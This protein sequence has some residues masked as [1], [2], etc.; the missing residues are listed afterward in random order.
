M[1]LGIDPSSYFEEMEAGAKYFYDGK[2]VEPLKLF[3]E[4]GVKLARA[5][6]WNDPYNEKGEPYLGGTTDLKNFIK[7]AK[8]LQSKGYDILVDFHYSDFWA[9]P[10][11]QLAP[12][13]WKDMTFEEVEKALYEFT[14]DS[15]LKSKAEGIKISYAQIGNEIT[16]GMCWPF[17]KLNDKQMPRSGYENLSRL[18][19]AGIKAARE[20]YPEI[21]ILIHLEKSYDQVI[22][23]EYFD[24]I[25]KNG[26]DFDIIGM[27]YY[28]HWHG[29]FKDFFAN[30]DMLHERYKK[31]IIIVETGYAWTLEDYIA[32]GQGHL[33]VGSD[34]SYGIFTNLEE[35]L[36]REGQANFVRRLKNLAKEHDILGIIY[37]EPCWIPGKNTCRASPAAQSYINERII[38]YRN[39]WSNQCL[40][41]YKG[42]AL[43]AFEEFIK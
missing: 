2:E 25:I 33:V 17:G 5:R 38:S 29:N 22:Y 43:P 7:L 30:V 27:S 40:F 9:D 32:D 18:L 8:L 41:D 12:K 6:I 10:G 24:N 14:K 42:V 1:I 20:V 31:P 11:R 23:R 13:A 16:N 3:N 26:V 28:Q 4:K 39:E 37:W 21:K 36:T 35:P 15:L 19:K 34:S